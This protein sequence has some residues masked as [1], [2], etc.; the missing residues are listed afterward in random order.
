MA[1]LLGKYTANPVARSAIA[2]LLSFVPTAIATLFTS[3]LLISHYGLP[4]FN[5]YI[6]VVTAIALIPLNDLGVGAAVTTNYAA[7]GPLD[8]LSRRVTLTAMRTLVVGTLVLELVN[9]GITSAGL[10][11]TLLGP[12]SGSNAQIGTAIAVYGLSFIPGLGQSM[13]LG[14]QRN[15]ITVIVQAFF[16]PLILVAVVALIAFDIRA[17]WAIVVPALAILVINMVTSCVAARLIGVRWRSLLREVPDRRR[18][19]GGKIRDISGPKLLISLT[20]PITLQGDRVVLSHVASGQ[21]VANY[22]VAGQIFAP[23][24]ALIAA[25]AAPLWPIYQRARAEG[26]AGPSLLR[27]VFAFVAVVGVVCLGLVLVAGP[28]GHLIGGDQVELGVLLPVAWGLVMMGQ[29]AAFVASMSMMGRRGIRFVGI[30]CV[31]GMPIGLVI[32]ILLGQAIGA[33]GP[34]FGTLIAVLLINTIPILIYRRSVTYAPRHGGG[35]EP[36][37]DVEIAAVGEAPIGQPPMGATPV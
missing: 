24:A 18:F 11:P 21:A 23:V 25:S 8:P 26:R 14:T 32:S 17:D 35:R 10:W 36:G 15:H 1:R 30:C 7:H 20:A 2:R 13:L 9:L 22:S 33:P 19:P 29:A 5:A 34:L 31:I 16:T 4:T 12:A 6:L 37:R 28:V 27:I 3:R